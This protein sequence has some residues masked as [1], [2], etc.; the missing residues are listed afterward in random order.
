MIVVSTE[1]RSSDY[2]SCFVLLARWRIHEFIRI[3]WGEKIRTSDWLIRNQSNEL[4]TPTCDSWPKSDANAGAGP[5]H[6]Q[7]S[8]EL[9][10]EITWIASAREKGRA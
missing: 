9:L 5:P 4:T 6:T 7:Q 1:C 2:R 8:G 10:T 3:C